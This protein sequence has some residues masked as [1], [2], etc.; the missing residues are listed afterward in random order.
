[1]SSKLNSLSDLIATDVHGEPMSEEPHADTPVGNEEPQTKKRG[2]DLNEESDQVQERE[3]SQHEA[4]EDELLQYF[5]DLEAKVDNCEQFI[6]Q[7]EEKRLEDITNKEKRRKTKE[8]ERRKRR[9]AEDE[10]KKKLKDEIQK[11]VEKQSFVN[12]SEAEAHARERVEK[13]INELRAQP[14]MY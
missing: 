7:L 2:R 9:E 8:E 14:Y 5:M 4:R 1:M 6:R 12:M 3:R 11:L 13:Q 10:E